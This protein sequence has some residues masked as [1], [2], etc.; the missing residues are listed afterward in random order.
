MIL[1]LS[2]IHICH[3][4]NLK[5][6]KNADQHAVDVGLKYVNNDACYPSIIVVGQLIEALQSGEYDLDNTTVIISQTAGGCRATN[7]IGFLRKA[8]ADAGFSSIPVLS[9]NVVGLE[10]NPGFKLSLPLFNNLI[11]AI[12]YGD[13][14]MRL[15]LRTR[16]YEINKGECDKLY[17]QWIQRCREATVR[18]KIS[19]IKKI[20]GQ[21]IADFE[22]VEI[23][24][25]IKPRVAVVGEIL[26]QYHPLANNNLIRNIEKEGGEAFQPDILNFFLYIA[27]QSEAK[28]RKLSRSFGGY[29]ACN[30]FIKMLNIYLAPIKKLLREHPRFGQLSNIKKLAG[31]A[32]SVLSL[33]NIT[34]EGWFL[35]AEMLE[36]IE[37]GIPNI[38]LLYT[39]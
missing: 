7:Y 10:K 5:I 29:A 14:L 11:L 1:Y 25:T 30:L 36:L 39:S 19:E 22:A 13:L 35:T 37:K 32:E 27:A 28:Y 9:L 18:G 31:K 2:L 15:L 38:C 8:L 20:A 21:M 4:Y 26:V 17:E 3:G 6:L 24:E 34:G 23:R 33:C 12:L 16:P